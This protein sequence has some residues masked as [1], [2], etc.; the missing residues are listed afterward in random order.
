MSTAIHDNVIPI[1]GPRTVKVDRRPVDERRELLKWLAE[2]WSK[3]PAAAREDLLAM[4]SRP[5]PDLAPRWDKYRI[6]AAHL[7]T[8]ENN[9]IDW[10]WRC[11]DCG[12]PFARCC[13]CACCPSAYQQAQDDA[14]EALAVLVG[15][16]R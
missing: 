13:E 15:S 8:V 5:Q 14:D 2:D 1:D 9:I 10:D 16:A 6:V 11:G 4:Y 7:E 3:L 12:H